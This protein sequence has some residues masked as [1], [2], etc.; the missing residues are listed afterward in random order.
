MNEKIA[1]KFIITILSNDG[2]A[3]MEGLNDMYEI[4]N[5]NK[6]VLIEHIKAIRNIMNKALEE[7]GKGSDK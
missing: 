2:N 4:Q 6:D 1:K 3:T 5:G 7:L